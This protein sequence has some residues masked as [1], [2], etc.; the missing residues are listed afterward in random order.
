MN[1]N[2]N[3]IR[4]ILSLESGPWK[5]TFFLD[6]NIYSIGRNSSNSLA[7]HHRV[8]S[9]NH[10]SL[11]K[12]TYGNF[13][14]EF[15][16]QSI[17]WI[18]DGDLKGNK[19]TNGIYV[20]GKQCNF[21]QLQ[22]GDLIFLGGI[23]VKA[24]YDIVD[25]QTRTFFSLSSESKNSLI[26]FENL[27]NKQ[28]LAIIK[29]EDVKLFEL[30]GEGVLIID[31]KTRQIL[32]A[33][34]KYCQLVNYSFE[35]ITTLSIDDLFVV[36]KSIFDHDLDILENYNIS[37]M[38]ESINKRK[39]KSFVNVLLNYTP[40]NFQN[41]KCILVTIQDINELK[42]VEEV[43][44]YQTTHDSLTNL[45]NKKLFREQLLLSLGHNLIKQEN[46]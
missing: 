7:I 31:I 23:E 25:L 8:I 11:I 2:N 15:Q 17:F 29:D 4:H 24:K 44:R 46:L 21:H 20:N 16:C 9:R 12:V 27:D 26:N 37:T 42:K 34:S 3:S 14:H 39:D 32:N 45:P 28:S 10:A 18:I 38:R 19:S 41:R 1:I 13:N 30:M 5:K 36:E 22:P 40:I 35:E 33:N 43:I 6:K